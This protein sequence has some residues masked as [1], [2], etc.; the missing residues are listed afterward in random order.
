[1]KILILGGTGAMGKSLVRILAQAGHN[2]T[3][4]SR[5][6][7]SLITPNVSYVKGNAHELTF[8][9][10][11]LSYRW[12][13][14]V[15]FMTYSSSEFQKRHKLL[16]ASTNQY[17]FLSSSRVYANSPL[18]DEKSPRLL[19]TTN[20]QKYLK[21][22]EYALA[23]ARQEIILEKSSFSKWVIIRP[24]IPYSEERL[25]LGVFEKE[26]W[27]YRALHGRKIV[28]SRDIGRCYTTMTLGLDVAKGIASIVGKKSANKE[29]F[30]ITASKAYLWQDILN[31][32]IST[33]SKHNN[34][35][36]KVQWIDQMTTLSQVMQNQY[37]VNMDRLCNRRFQ[38]NKIQ[39]F[40]D[41]KLNFE[42]LKFALPHCLD[43]FLLSPHFRKIDWG[44]QAHMDKL[45][46]E[47]TP[48][49]EIPALK[50]KIKYILF[51]YLPV[52]IPLKFRDII[53]QL[54][55]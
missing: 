13:V 5:S 35:C 27:L 42:D 47:Y 29:I 3:V 31:L 1:M 48:M 24:Y 51:R 46:H 17:I 20:D 34:I 26:D 9:K 2:V 14:I 49:R 43:G 39:Y 10:K 12:D 16:L 30:Q 38:S 23:K 53:R 22:D 40:S 45:S 21:T 41:N 55:N 19:E 37:Q 33:L 25:Q 36:I 6:S 32:Y 28:F 4:T 52:G 11:L 8:L 15:D 54:S 50:D 7:H 18:L 44:T